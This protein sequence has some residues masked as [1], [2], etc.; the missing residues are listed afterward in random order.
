MSEN[1]SSSIVEALTNN[2]EFT[3]KVLPFLKL[4]YFQTQS[5]KEIFKVSQEFF[6]KYDT[7][8]TPEILK[9][10]LN[11]RNIPEAVHKECIEEVNS[12]SKIPKQTEWLVESAEKFCR[13]R[14]IYNAMMTALYIMDGKEKKISQNEI[15]ELLE[16]ALGVCFDN[17]VG[18]DFFEDAAERFDFYT[19]V[20]NK[21]PFDIDML[22]LITKGGYTFKTLNLVAA[23][24]GV[25]KTIFGCHYAASCLKQGFDVLYITMEMSEEKISERIDANLLGIDLD[26]IKFL[27][28]ENYLT[29]IDKIKQK[30]SGRLIVKEYPST[31]GHAGLFKTL[32]NE[33]KIKKGFV[34]KVII[35]DYLNICGSRRFS[36]GLENSF[37]MVKAVSEELRG[38]AQTSNTVMLT[39]TQFN[40]S[41]MES[42]D[43]ELSDT[44]ES[45]GTTYTVDSYFAMNEPEE[46]ARM[47]QIL[48]KQLKNRYADKNK[49]KRFLVGLDKSKMTFYNLEASGQENLSELPA[50]PQTK[51]ESKRDKFN[52]F[53]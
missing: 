10:E 28:K 3:R 27:D 37:G 18:H 38:L 25:G 20:E 30:T 12:F 7:L 9:I 23:A 43:N 13:D 47:N 26:D 4:E 14:A 40:R 22:N 36:G 21:I 8:P 46:L 51:K 41:G 17:S 24:T 52:Q 39:F 53:K 11:Q 34:P 16:E 42:S 48:W 6:E 5:E 1:I 49:H 31:E 15:P 44:S 19:K 32:L 45:I 29:R 50:P 33:L 2:E 35:V